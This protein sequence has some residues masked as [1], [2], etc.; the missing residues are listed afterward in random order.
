MADAG[1]PSSPV[2]V[3]NAVP[4]A[5]HEPPA[6]TGALIEA[7]SED[8]GKAS[9]EDGGALEPENV[10]RK[11]ELDEL[12]ALVPADL[13]ADAGCSVTGLYELVGI[14]THKGADA[15]GGHYIGY[16][17]K[18]AL[19]PIKI[20]GEMPVAPEGS[21]LTGVA[22][23]EDDEDWYKFDDEKVSIFPSD[24][25]PTLEGG[26]KNY[27]VFSNRRLLTFDRR[28]FICICVTVSLQTSRIVTLNQDSVRSVMR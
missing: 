11:R 8:K 10:Y 13:K 3:Q 19:H 6:P 12:E 22:L 14:I 2:L 24:K 28:G 17:K 5:G 4:A 20:G 7:S 18:S 1:A 16:V 9:A 23:E 26:G 21:T 25:I 27:I 15:D